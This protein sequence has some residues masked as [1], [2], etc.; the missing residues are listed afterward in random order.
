MQLNQE[1]TLK[2]HGVLVTASCLFGGNTL[3]SGDENGWI[4]LW[5]LNTRRPLGVWKAHDERIITLQAM[6]KTHLL[7]HG[8]DSRI[9]IWTMSNTT[10]LKCDL[11]FDEDDEE[12]MIRP[13]FS[14][15]AVNSLN[16]CN[17][18]YYQNRLLAPGTLNSENIDVYLLFSEDGLYKPT[19][20][21]KLFDGFKLVS[22][23]TN[24]SDELDFS[25]DDGSTGK[26]DGFGI[27]MRLHTIDK[28]LFVVG[29]ENGVV[30]GVLVDD[31]GSQL[32]LK[33][34]DNSMEPNPVTWMGL[35]LGLSGSRDLITYGSTTSKLCLYKCD[36]GDKNTLNVGNSGIQLALMTLLLLL[37]VGFWNGLVRGIDVT[38][39]SFVFK[40][41]RKTPMLDNVATNV[42]RQQSELPSSSPYIK[43]TGM[44]NIPKPCEGS[45]AE[46]VNYRTRV[47]M[48]FV[49]EKI[50]ITYDDGSIV[51]FGCQ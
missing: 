10:D 29:Y 14:E 11:A 32:T 36:T 7:S 35:A 43:M 6:D 31:L 34:M 15:L 38:D 39:G 47:R 22:D 16:F 2:G 26:R 27:V 13:D 24:S 21:V 18:S 33:F 25:G 46:V 5:N 41:S 49:G 44:V 12:D 1:F 9:R 4:I 50:A 48:K 17:V 28:N 37:I 40:V 45:L 30:L 20:L 19:R 42:A 51:V 8:R 23:S 3:V